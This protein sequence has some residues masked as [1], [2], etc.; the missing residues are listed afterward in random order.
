MTDSALSPKD[1]IRKLLLSMGQLGASDLHLK[2][3]V[4]PYYRIAKHLRKVDMPPLPDNK[5]LEEA[6]FDLIPKQRRKEFQE[7]GDVDFSARI[8]VLHS[9]VK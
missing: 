3:G 8:G 9:S 6:I 1:T 5:F 7:G 4:V 2:V